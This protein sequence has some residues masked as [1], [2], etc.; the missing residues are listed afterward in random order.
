M[1]QARASR[2]SASVI[3]RGSKPIL[4]SPVQIGVDRQIRR[5]QVQVEFLEFANLLN[6][7]PLLEAE[8]ERPDQQDDAEPSQRALPRAETAAGD[9][10]GAG[11]GELRAGR[12]GERHARHGGGARLLQTIQGA[13]PELGDPAVEV[14]GQLP[15]EFGFTFDHG[16][17]PFAFSRSARAR[18]AR[19]QWVFTLPSEQPIAAAVSATSSS[20]Q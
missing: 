9:A 1:R 14:M 17:I 5:E 3:E 11:G 19:E 2:G 8:S 18:T 10:A 4:E 6:R 20:S 12:G 7:L 15:G 16:V 13:R